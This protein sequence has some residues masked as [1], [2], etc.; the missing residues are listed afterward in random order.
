[1]RAQQGRAKVNNQE[2]KFI[3]SAY[4][5]SGEDACDAVFA[6][7]LEQV[8]RDPGLAAWFAGQRALDVAT[9]NAICS[10]PIPQ[11]LRANILAGAKISRR[12]FWGRGP[13]L[14]AIAASLVL[15]AV[16]NGVWTHQSHGDR[17]QSDAL[18]V[19]STFVPGQ[20]PFDH[21]ATD[22]HELQRWLQ[23]QHEPTV[24]VIPAALQSL[25][26]LG[27]KTISSAGKPVSIIC[28]KMR[29]GGLVHLVVT[30][31][32]TLKDAPPKQPRFARKGDWI[33]AS[34]T[35]NGRA[36]MLATKGAGQGLRDLLPTAA[37]V[38]ADYFLAGTLI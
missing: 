29:D 2:A 38:R 19:I 33:T 6:A 15:L 1:M 37:R 30:D 7:A 35:E 5:P 28:F 32:S 14:L 10:I 8:N 3:L 31:A 26:A 36:C 17:W 27:C 4:R 11:D 20:E 24:E 12:R 23:A 18:A 22:S 25:P 21:K 9:T 34:W 16:I 13:V